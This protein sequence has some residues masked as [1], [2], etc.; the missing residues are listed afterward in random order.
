MLAK[1]IQE[2]VNKKEVLIGRYRRLLDNWTRRMQ[3]DGLNRVL[4]DVVNS[5]EVVDGLVVNSASNLSKLASLD[6]AFAKLNDDMY[7]QLVK[8]I[9]NGTARLNALNSE[10][11]ALTLPNMGRQLDAAL[12]KA[13]TRMSYKLGIRDGQLVKNGWME[14][15]IKDTTV[16][17]NVKDGLLKGVLS[18]ASFKDVRQTVTEI[19]IGTPDAD[20]GYE[21]YLKNSVYDVFQQ[22][23]AAYSEQVEADL[24]LKYFIYTGGLV[25]DSRDICREHNARVWSAEEAEEWATWTPSQ[26]IYITE[27]KQKNIYAVPSYLGYAGYD[28]LIDRGGFNCRHQLAWIS[29]ERAFELRP[30]LKEN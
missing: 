30:E 5:L 27:F 1:P 12:N 7:P 10:F 11:F 29:D 9:S 13:A 8:I 22:H 23:D 16:L 17:R 4:S 19:L 26:S 20:G 18:G 2:I 21:R 14:S 24:D 15:L 6:A 3:F 25:D 28:P